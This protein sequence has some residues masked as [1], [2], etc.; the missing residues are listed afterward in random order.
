MASRVD[1]YCDEYRFILLGLHHIWHYFGDIRMG[2]V[3]QYHRHLMY[4]SDNMGADDTYQLLL[5]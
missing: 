5:F 4:S 3:Q 2:S 1:N